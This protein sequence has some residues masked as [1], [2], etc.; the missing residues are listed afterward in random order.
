MVQREREREC[1]R[2][3]ECEREREREREKE[4]EEMSG[5]LM[6]VATTRLYTTRDGEKEAE[7]G[8]GVRG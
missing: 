1:V 7:R 6:L 5:T 4:R 8:G 2:E 3:R